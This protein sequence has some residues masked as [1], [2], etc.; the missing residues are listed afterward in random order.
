MTTIRRHIPAGI[1]Y[2]VTPYHITKN[3][4]VIGEGLVVLDANWSCEILHIEN[5]YATVKIKNIVFANGRGP[6]GGAVDSIAK[7]LILEDCTF[8]GDSAHEGS[9]IHSRGSTYAKNCSVTGNVARNT[10][11]FTIDGADLTID[12]CVFEDNY[13]LEN[14]ASIYCADDVG[15][16]EPYIHITNSS[17]RRNNVSINGSAIY[18]KGR[19]VCIESSDFSNNSG[20]TPVRIEQ[21][22]AVIRNCEFTNNQ[23]LHDPEQMP[24]C[25]I[26]SLINCSATIENCVIADNNVTARYW[27]GDN[28]GSVGG[29][30]ISN[31]SVIMN[32]T[33]IER[34]VAYGM[35]ALAVASYSELVMNGGSISQNVVK[36]SE[37]G[38]N[39]NTAGIGIWPEAKVTL[40]GVT[41][42]DNYAD[43]YSGAIC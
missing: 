10:G 41:F 26:I 28:G 36:F 12:D 3:T 23:R 22:H 8:V 33:N 27:T 16:K 20:T 37:D 9:C 24:L 18:S 14:G 17:F 32:N 11:A 39:G 40:N 42:E 4:T 2:N 7:S 13:V 19:D 21:G 34:N 29:I 31:A 5:P 35:G 38:V 43:G 15:S 6:D 30:Y 1:Y 25:G